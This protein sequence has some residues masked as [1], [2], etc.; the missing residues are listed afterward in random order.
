MGT[1][2]S[3]GVIIM[4]DDPFEQFRES[5]YDTEQYLGKSKLPKGKKGQK[6]R[7]CCLLI[8]LKQLG[9]K[10]ACSTRGRQLTFNEEQDF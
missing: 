6:R 9:L 5:A 2:N 8:S 10:N 7:R 1:D 3:I 4:S